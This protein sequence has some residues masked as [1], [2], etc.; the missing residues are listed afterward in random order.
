MALVGESYSRAYSV[1]V[2]IQLLSELEDLGS[3]QEDTAAADL[4]GPTAGPTAGEAWQS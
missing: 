1:M 4:V 3:G 2:S